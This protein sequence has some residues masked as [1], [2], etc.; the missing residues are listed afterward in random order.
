MNYMPNSQE[1]R[2]IAFHMHSYTNAITHAEVGPMIM[3]RGEGIHVFDNNGTKYIEAMSGLW[4]A[5]LGFSEER[6]IK[7]ATDQ[8]RTLPFYHNFTHKS[9]GKAIDLA[10][11]LISIAPV[12]MSKVF[13]TNSGSEANDTVIKMIWYRSNAL[14][15]HEKKKVISRIRG[16]HGVTLASA[17]LTGLPYNH[18]SFDLPIDRVHHTTCPHFWREGHEGET[19]EQFATRCATNLEDMILAE[20]PETVAAFFAEPVMGAGGVVI[21]PVTYWEKIQTVLN[22]YD[23]LLIA[24]EVICGFGR[25]GK[26]FGSETYG[27]KPDVLV[28]SKQITSSYA[29]F[30]A[31]MINDKF[32]EPIAEESGRIGVLGHGFTGAGHPVGAAIA[33]ENIAI[34]EERDLVAKTAENGKY[35]QKKLREFEEHPIVGEVRGVGLIAAVELVTNKETKAGL[36]KPGALGVHINKALQRNGIISRSIVDSA[37]LCPPLIIER[38]Q[39][40]EIISAMHKSLDEVQAEIS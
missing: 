9:H 33:L 2:D 4:S 3:E 30:S 32:Y 27:M 18:K 14:G 37:A 1:A 28:M 25:T 15:L 40:D 12:P 16:Y 7:A 22:K 29:P 11:K 21:P 26:M 5:A 10:E 35:M 23:V 36:E 17:S 34:I 20:G 8:M 24:D 19:E 6:L 31:F 39:I 13:Y 38:K